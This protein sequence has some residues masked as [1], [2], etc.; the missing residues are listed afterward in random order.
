ME[1]ITTLTA[2]QEAAL[3]DFQREWLAHHAETKNAPGDKPGALCYAR[4]TPRMGQGQRR[5]IC[6][7]RTPTNM[8]T[9]EPT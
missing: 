3:A 9:P 2:H 5:G 7:S 1:K 6:P 8:P 4:L